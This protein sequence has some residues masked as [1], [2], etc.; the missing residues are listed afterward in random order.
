M[1]DREL[2]PHVS[3]PTTLSGAESTDLFGVTDTRK[4]VKDVYS[5]G[6]VLGPCDRL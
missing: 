5:S 4:R 6:R 2:V 1:I 3:I